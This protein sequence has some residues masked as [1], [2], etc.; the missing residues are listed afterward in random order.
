[1]SCIYIKMGTHRIN[2]FELIHPPLELDI[3]IGHKFKV[4]IGICDNHLSI[5]A[6]G[7][8]VPGGELLSRVRLL[9]DGQLSRRQEGGNGVR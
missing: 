2:S 3:G 8:A 9:K 6:I 4:E 7:G 5:V 1:M